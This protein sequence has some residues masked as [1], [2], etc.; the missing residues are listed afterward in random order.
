[1]SKKGCACTS[2][3]CSTDICR[4]MSAELTA[5][6]KMCYQHTAAHVCV[7]AASV[8]QPCTVHP[9]H[10]SSR[11]ALLTTGIT[12]A[13]AAQHGWSSHYLTIGTVPN[14]VGILV[15]CML[16]QPGASNSVLQCCRCSVAAAATAQRQQVAEACVCKR[17]RRQQL[18]A[19]DGAS[20]T[21][22]ADPRSSQ[23]A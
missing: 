14:S 10:H 15:A 19:C 12:G 4:K 9:L 3:T 5:N 11:S 16:W 22:T 17:V 18:P 20:F 7:H 6:I 2:C 21:S 13:C 1:L 23:Q 8:R